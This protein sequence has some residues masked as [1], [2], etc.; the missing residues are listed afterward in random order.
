ESEDE[1]V[2]T[3]PLQDLARDAL[4]LEVGV[5]G[6]LVDIGG[7]MV[8]V[9][10]VAP[11]WCAT[12]D[13]SFQ[14]SG[15]LTEGPVVVSTRLLR[16]GSRVVTVRSEVF[17]GRG[18]ERPARH[19]GTA[20]MTFSRIPRDASGVAVD[21]A[22]D[23][24]PPVGERRELTDASAGFGD[25]PATAMGLRH[26][27][28]GVVE[29]DKTPY[30]LNSFGTVN[31]GATAI[32]LAAAAQSAVED[33]VAVDLSIR[34]VGQAGIGPVRTVARELADYDSYAS[35]DVELVDTS[36]DDRLIALGTVGLVRE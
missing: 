5:V 13:L 17:D 31:G 26:I 19:A 11:D 23:P 36:A 12:S 24:R 3:A 10:N 33:A 8:A 7:A 16:A 1:L 35:V 22:V 34:Y 2:V 14:R 9:A 29:L 28:P 25:A 27:E 6:A 4:G 15:G 18:E 20:V 30:V 21:E 32:T